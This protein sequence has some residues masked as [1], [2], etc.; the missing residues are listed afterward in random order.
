[1]N[2]GLA[3]FRFILLKLVV[4]S[5]CDCIPSLMASL[6][7]FTGTCIICSSSVMFSAFCLIISLTD[8]SSI[9]SSSSSNSGMASGL[10][11]L[12]VTGFCFTFSMFFEN[13]CAAFA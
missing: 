3:T 8:S 11:L 4:S 13:L 6:M 1:M 9:T 5:P 7:S 12:T 2:R 10:F